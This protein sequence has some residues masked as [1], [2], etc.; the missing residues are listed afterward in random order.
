MR[1]SPMRIKKEVPGGTVF[2]AATGDW[3]YKLTGELF[4]RQVALT[5]EQEAIDAIAAAQQS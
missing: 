5:S 1:K 4:Y 3:T 2:K